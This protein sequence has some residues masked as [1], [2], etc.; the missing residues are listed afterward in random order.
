M[1]SYIKGIAL[2]RDNTEKGKSVIELSRGLNIISGESKT[3]KSAIIDIIDWCLGASECKIPKGKITRFAKLYVL[4]IDLNSHCI[5]LAR[6]DEYSRKNYIFIDEISRN[7]GIKDIDLSYFNEDKFIKISEALDFINIKMDISINSENLPFEFEK[8]MPK[9]N[10]RNT[11]PFIF[12]TQD[13]IDSKTNL[14]YQE[15]KVNHF[16]VLAG[17]FG[18]EYYEILKSIEKLQSSIKNLN[19]RQ[20]E[21]KTL[22]QK[23]IENL[24]ISLQQHYLLNDIEFDENWSI[25]YCLQRI[26]KLEIFKK[27]EYSNELQKKQD[28][29][30]ETI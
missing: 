11:L 22:N 30:V 5:L 19:A 10:I 1:N 23:L 18:A 6:E 25:E 21:A 26:K 2:F 24:K 7:I 4:L 20:E 12:Q 3:G 8:K 16:P 14:F 13:I 9:T 27:V 17:W 28:E 15:P 29:L